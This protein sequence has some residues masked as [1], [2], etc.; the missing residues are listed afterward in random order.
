MTQTIV[1]FL[2]HNSRQF[3]NEQAPAF[4]FALAAIAGVPGA[5]EDELPSFK[6]CKFHL[7]E[8]SKLFPLVHNAP[9][10]EKTLAKLR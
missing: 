4:D 10:E 2:L 7:K 9:T 1:D 5:V 8:C 6:F 3:V